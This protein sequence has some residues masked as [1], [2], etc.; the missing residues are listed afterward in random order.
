MNELTLSV[1]IT[2]VVMVLG[3]IVSQVVMVVK[4]TSIAESVRSEV[5][6][7]REI[8]FKQVRI[9]VDDTAHPGNSEPRG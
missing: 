7:L 6:T 4:M 2:E 5:R 1:S 9:C 3:F 8:V